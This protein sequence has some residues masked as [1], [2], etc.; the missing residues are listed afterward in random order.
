MAEWLEEKYAKSGHPSIEEL[1]RAQSTIQTA[2]P[3]DLIG[4]FWPEEE[5]IDEFLSMLR[6]WRG[7]TEADRAA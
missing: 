5:D 7:H 4:D 3:R 1:K 6:Q 2:D